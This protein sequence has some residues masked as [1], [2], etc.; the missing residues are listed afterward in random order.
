MIEQHLTVN[1]VAARLAVSHKTVR[2]LLDKGELAGVKIA[3][4]VRVS[5]SAL[6]EY[7]ERQ[8]MG[9]PPPVKP[10]VP[11]RIGK[12]RLSGRDWFA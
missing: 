12:L 9:K 7:L 1:E 3:G 11:K 2:K 5:E 8:A 4:A 10:T 6:A